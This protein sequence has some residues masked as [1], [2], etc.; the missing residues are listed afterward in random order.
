LKKI[1][2]T[3]YIR[4]FV[5]CIFITTIVAA[6]NG[7]NWNGQINVEDC[8]SDEINMINLLIEQS[9][10]TMEWDM[11]T[12][13]D[14]T[15]G[16]LEVGWQFW[17]DGHLI[18]WICSDVPSPWYVYNYNCGLSGDVMNNFSQFSKLEKLHI[19]FNQ[20]SG[21]ISEDFCHSYFANKS[22]Y[23]LRINNNEMCPPFP[24]CISEK[25]RIQNTSNC[26]E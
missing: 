11:D 23:W 20:I 7:F 5:G 19:D 17:E 8:D 14:G 12:D 13:F 6:C 22:D 24:E 9:S 4:K 25:N 18:H 1:N 15:I 16:P 2:T 21:I 3:K 10:S 26:N